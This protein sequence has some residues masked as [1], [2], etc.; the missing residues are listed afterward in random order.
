MAAMDSD[1]TVSR[2]GLLRTAAVATGGAVAGVSVLAQPAGAA[3]GDPVRMGYVNSAGTSS[4]GITST[5]DNPAFGVSNYGNGQAVEL[6]SYGATF[7][8][9]LTVVRSSDSG[10]AIAA[11]GGTSGLTADGGVVGVVATGGDVGVY[12]ISH[13]TLSS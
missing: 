7:A 10:M 4:T 6:Y 13:G 9:T 3:D 12:A 1:A 5:T 11:S 8:A 2:R